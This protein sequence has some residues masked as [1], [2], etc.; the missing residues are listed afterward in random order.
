[1][2]ANPQNDRLMRAVCG[3]DVH[4]DSAFLC[5]LCETSEIIEKI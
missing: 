1:M 2:I 4:K 5:I 3:L